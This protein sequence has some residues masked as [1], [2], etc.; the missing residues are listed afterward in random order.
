MFQN[1]PYPPILKIFLIPLSFR[2]FFDFRLYQN[3]KH[4]LMAFSNKFSF[5][6]CLK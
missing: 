4:K 2:M 5:F 1:A 3:T 6:G